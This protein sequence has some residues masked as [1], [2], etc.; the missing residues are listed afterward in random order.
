[1]PL[2]ASIGGRRRLALASSA[3]CSY[4]STR[5]VCMSHIE[6]SGDACATD[7][8]RTAPGLSIVGSV[9]LFTFFRSMLIRQMLLVFDHFSSPGS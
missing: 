7:E 8:A 3:R 4:L 2:W 9:S 6:I 5:Y 1:M